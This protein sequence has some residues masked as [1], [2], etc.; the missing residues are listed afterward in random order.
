MSGD[1]IRKCRVIMRGC[2]CK[3]CVFLVGRLQELDLMAAGISPFAPLCVTPAAGDSFRGD[4]ES[5][6]N[7]QYRDT[8][9]RDMPHI[10]CFLVLLLVTATRASSP[11]IIFIVADDMVS[12]HS[13]EIRSEQETNTMEQ[14]PPWEANSHSASQE[15]SR[16]SSLLFSGYR[17][18][19]PCW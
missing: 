2:E 12:W 10:Q 9:A 5:I 4:S 3:K 1:S 13:T 18:L 8:T 15:I 14:S 16:L 19:F 17:E 11:H 7:V 6:T